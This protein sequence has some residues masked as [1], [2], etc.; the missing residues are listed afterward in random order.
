MLPLTL[1][2]LYLAAPF[3]YVLKKYTT[4]YSIHLACNAQSLNLNKFAP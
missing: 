4:C 2:S 1:R 3:K